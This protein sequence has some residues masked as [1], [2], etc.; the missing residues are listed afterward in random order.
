MMQ[1]A[2]RTGCL[3]TDSKLCGA[4]LSCTLLLAAC[5]LGAA[6]VSGA[7]GL[8]QEFR[9]G[10]A[11][12]CDSHGDGN[13]VS[14]RLPETNIQQNSGGGL[15]E[16]P[17]SP[18]Q[19]VELLTDSVHF[20]SADLAPGMEPSDTPSFHEV[21]SDRVPRKL[22]KKS[23]VRPVDEAETAFGEG[24]DMVL[25]A[26][27]RPGPRPDDASVATDPENAFKLSKSVKRK[28][29]RADT[30]IEQDD[31]AECDA[32]LQ[33]VEDALEQEALGPIENISMVE[34]VV[35]MGVVSEKQLLEGVEIPPVMW[36]RHLQQQRLLARHRRLCPQPATASLTV[37]HGSQSGCLAGGGELSRS[38]AIGGHAL[39]D[40]EERLPSG[41]SCGSGRRDAAV[42]PGEP[43]HPSDVLSFSKSEKQPSDEGKPAQGVGDE[44]GAKG[45]VHHS[46][47]EAPSE[48]RVVSGGAVG[49][50][51]T[52]HDRYDSDD[53]WLV[54]SSE[55]NMEVHAAQESYLE[56]LDPGIGAV[57]Q[58]LH[59]RARGKPK[60]K[61]AKKMALKRSGMQKR[62]SKE[63]CMT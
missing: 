33:R 44:S 5:I 20:S 36:Q 26:G 23:A 37:R 38:P 43:A 48:G 34:L 42:A 15:S 4:V 16:A 57:A 31:A 1:Q 62:P 22:H 59:R 56:K 63:L 54:T 50:R 13:P 28:A 39:P 55:I 46:R 52:V 11:D 21:A 41:P 32:D 12:S 10:S 24:Q 7:S 35:D 49:E 9:E 45:P 3:A 61:T 58:Q 27:Q 19:D 17:E 60:K 53:S 40:R 47:R 18:Q 2:R 29:L 51:K 14:G 30:R 8:G 25:S 6:E